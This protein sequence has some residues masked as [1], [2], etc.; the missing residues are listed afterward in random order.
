MKARKFAKNG[1]FWVHSGSIIGQSWVENWSK[2]GKPL[3]NFLLD[4]AIV[5][6]IR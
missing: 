2:V 6:R 4:N 3:V 1:L 5:E